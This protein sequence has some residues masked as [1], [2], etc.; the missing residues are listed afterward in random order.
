MPEFNVRL[1]CAR[2]CLTRIPAPRLFCGKHW[3]L[4]PSVLQMEIADTWKI[5]AEGLNALLGKAKDAVAA[6]ERRM[7]AC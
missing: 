5:D 7:P 6:A 1:C 3:V 2:R 4:V